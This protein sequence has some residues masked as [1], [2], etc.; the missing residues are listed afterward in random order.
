MKIATS[1]VWLG[2]A[3]LALL[4]ATTLSAF[5]QDQPLAPA[6]P[7]GTM[8]ATPSSP[9]TPQPLSAQ[10]QLFAVRAAEGNLAEVLTSE[11]ALKNTK[12][13]DVRA[14]AQ[15][16]IQEHGQ[17]Q[18]QLIGILRSHGM[19]PPSMLSAGHTV[20]YTALKKAKNAD[21]DRMYMA[22]QVDDHENTIALFATEV[23]GG[24]DDALKGYASTYLP[25]ILGHTVM[26]Y[27]VARAVKAPGIEMRPQVPPSPPGFA[28]DMSG[29]ADNAPSSTRLPN[30]PA[31]PATLPPGGALPN[32]L[33]APPTTPPGTMPN[34]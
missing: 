6:P 9:T 30:P 34:Q 15:K 18:T 20:I 22:T 29:M 8:P 26:I 25:P 10:D 5:A 14:T 13:A 23:S 1:S 19:A 7:M 32:T 27:N 21:F 33:P 12:N 17:A 3:A 31:P 2:G 16:L 4:S 11:L 24:Q 28:P